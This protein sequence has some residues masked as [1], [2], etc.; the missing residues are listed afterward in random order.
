MATA[1]A[2]VAIVYSA[3]SLFYTYGFDGSLLYTQAQDGTYIALNFSGEKI[4]YITERQLAAGD[5]DRHDLIIAPGITH[6]PAEA[7]DG[8]AAYV[9]G[10]RTL[11]FVSESMTLRDD[12]DGA[13]DHTFDGATLLPILAPEDL[14]DRLRPLLEALPGG[15]PVVVRMAE[16]DDEPWGVEWLHTTYEGRW[17]VNLTNYGKNPVTVRIDGIPLEG[18][19]DLLTGT[20]VD[21]TLTIE[22][23][24]THLVAVEVD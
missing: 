3:A 7:A 1:P 10:E 17:L 18:R 20:P 12:E 21:D 14:R 24:A 15:R 6:L 16:S 19:V 4:D 5:A 23:L 22:P 8:L 9:E 2:R 13:L 11:V